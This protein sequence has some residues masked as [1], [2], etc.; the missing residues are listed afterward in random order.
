MRHRTIH[1]LEFNVPAVALS[2][3]G[4]LGSCTASDSHEKLRIAALSLNNSSIACVEEVKALKVQ[5]EAAPSCLALKALARTYA[6]LGGFGG[7]IPRDIEVVAERAR[8]YA[9]MA[10]A[11]A[12]SG[13]PSIEIW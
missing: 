1:R 3:A 2:V 4:L 10:R 13:N 5:Y 11:I 9:W 8:A 7:N 12:T 6:D